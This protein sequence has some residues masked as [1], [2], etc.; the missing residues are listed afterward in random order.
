[1]TIYSFNVVGQAYGLLN[2]TKITEVRVFLLA[3]F[4]YLFFTRFVIN[5][6]SLEQCGY[7]D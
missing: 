1:M 5:W 4:Y 3:L 6:L 7:V 2:V